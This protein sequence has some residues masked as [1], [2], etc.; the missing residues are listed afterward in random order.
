MKN[1]TTTKILAILMI[2]CVLCTCFTG[3]KKAI[4]TED[5]TVSATITD[6][7]HKNSWIQPVRVGKV[8][9]MVSH[10]EKNIVH[11]QYENLTLSVNNKS[12][13]NEC[14]D[15]VGNNI[16]IILRTTYYD[17]GTSHKRLVYEQ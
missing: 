14:K 5:Q 6:V 3:C 16:D 1:K 12:L 17:D 8:S 2:I 11:L 15:N 9:S 4:R 10:P 7:Y 13:Y